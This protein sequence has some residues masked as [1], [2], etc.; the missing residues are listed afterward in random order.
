MMCFIFIVSNRQAT[1]LDV[2]APINY[3]NCTSC[4]KLRGE[5]SLCLLKPMLLILKIVRASFFFPFI[6]IKKLNSEVRAQKAML[7]S[8]AVIYYYFARSST[9]TV[10]KQHHFL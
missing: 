7:T 6:F 10:D 9:R 2:I 1:S 5:Q 8:A 3:T 4:V